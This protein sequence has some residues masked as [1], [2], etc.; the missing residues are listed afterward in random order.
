ASPNEHVAVAYFQTGA[1]SL[2]EEVVLD[3]PSFARTYSGNSVF[4]AQWV[5]VSAEYKPPHDDVP[6]PPYLWSTSPMD[7]LKC[8]L[9]AGEHYGAP[10]STLKDD[11]PVGSTRVL[12]E[13]RLVIRAAANGDDV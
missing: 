6:L 4:G 3:D 9:T 8:V 2:V 7:R 12:H 1:A 10:I 11:G 13:H 5:A